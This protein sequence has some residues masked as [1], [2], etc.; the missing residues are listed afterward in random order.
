Q[1][2]AGA[3][4]VDVNVGDGDGAEAGAVMAAA[5]RAVQHAGDL[6]VSVDSARPEV[7]EAGLKEAVGKPLLNSCPASA[8]ARRRLLPL[9]RRWGA[10][11]VGLPLGPRGIPATAA[12]RLRL[13]EK[14]VE[15]ALDEGIA[16]S[17]LY[18]DPLMLTAAH[19]D[20]AV[21][22]DTL[23]EIKRQFGVRTVM[24]V[25]NISHG[26][27][28]RPALNAAAFAY[29]A[30]AGLDL[31]LVNPLDERMREAMAAVGVLVGGEAGV[32]A[33]VSA[34]EAKP[35]RKATP[36]RKA[37]A[38]EEL[39]AAVVEGRRAAAA[40]AARRATRAGRKPLAVNDKYVLPALEEVGRRYEAGEFYLPHVIRAAEAAQA[41]FEVLRKSI[42]R[43]AGQ[44]RGRVVFATVAGDVHDI[45]KN[46]VAAVLRSHGFDVH[47]LGK[48]VPT[49][50]VVAAAKERKADLVALSALMTTTMPEMGK[51]AE[52]LRREGV[53]APL[54]VG[55]AVVT[56]KYARRIGASY[57]PNAVA[58][59]RLARRLTR[60]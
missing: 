35:R 31:A 13:V 9:A 45:G 34:S 38:G 21:T 53:R 40:E 20:A 22:F 55:G 41:T 57:A 48:S 43:A 52:A 17:D 46:V 23:R 32:A 15:H 19:G 11:V 16:L 25:S 3:A 1:R 4:V 28:R 56:E 7:L 30:G 50:R 27:P 8:A 39:Y 5:V 33:F 44:A 37:T 36:K 14:F 10:A 12:A 54:L 47:D 26:L 24:G 59:A 60:R 49:A 42:G 2:L 58:A 18:V 6:P 29:A 51:V